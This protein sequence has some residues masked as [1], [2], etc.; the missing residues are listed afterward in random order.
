MD[1]SQ[2]NCSICGSSLQNYE[3]KMKCFFCEK[4]FD[5]NWKCQNNHYICD[6]CRIAEP[7]EIIKIVCKNTSLK[8]P[9]K[10]ANKIMSHQSFNNHGIEH[11]YLVAPVILAALKNNKIDIKNNINNRIIAG[12]IKKIKDIPYGVCGSRGDCGACVSA[13]AAM[14]I[15]LKSSYK[16]ASERSKVLE[17]TSKCLKKLADYGGIRCCKQSVYSAIE[18]FFEIFSDENNGIY[19]EKPICKFSNII[20]ICKKDECPYYEKN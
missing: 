2:F 12:S 3:G 20:K 1:Y 19:F 9:Y 13:G 15:V 17:T 6:D 4:E 11:H 8:N 18:T 10:I 5:A 14:G 16:K 7:D